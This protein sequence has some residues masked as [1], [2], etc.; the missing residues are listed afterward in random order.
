MWKTIKASK[1]LNV[2]WIAQF[3]VMA[4]V[5]PKPATDQISYT[6]Q[7]DEIIIFMN[8]IAFAR[9]SIALPGGVQVVVVLPGQIYQDTLVLRENGKR[10]SNYHTSYDNAQ[11]IVR[12]QSA[13]GNGL[14]QVTLEYLLS[15]I[16]WT[17]KYDMWLD[18]AKVAVDSTSPGTRDDEGETIDFDFF[19]EIQNSVLVLDGVDVKLVA[20]RVDT[21]RQVDSVSMVTANQSIVGYE[22]VGATDGPVGVASIQYVYEVQD[23][24]ADPGDSVYTSLQEALLPARRVLLWNA[25]VDDQVTVIYKMRNE[26]EL[27]FAE[28]IVR[29]YQ[30]DMFLGSDFIELTPIG[31]EGSI[32]VGSLQDVRVKRDE[33]RTAIDGSWERDTQHDVELKLTNFSNETV[34][35]DV[36]DH[37]PAEGIDFRFSLEP[38][39]QSGNL[40]R[41]QVEM[42]PGETMTITYQFKS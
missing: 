29:A 32:T 10:V 33:T 30:D 21:T 27:P 31:G 2:F 22:D 12:W 8:N 38:Q 17:P 9:D 42:E 36:V 14:R 1:W 20:G 24:S 35:I 19:A 26:S 16:S 25:A 39:K 11:T 37:Y 3:A 34:E 40:F 7:P 13:S 28:G 5:A 18:H 23:V 4:I 41:W 15:G 6:S